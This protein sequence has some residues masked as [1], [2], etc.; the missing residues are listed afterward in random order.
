MASKNCFYVFIQKTFLKL[1]IHKTC[2]L[3]NFGTSW[4]QIE[5]LVPYWIVANYH[6]ILAFHLFVILNNNKKTFFWSQW[7]CNKVMYQYSKFELHQQ[8]SSIYLL[9]WKNEK[10]SYKYG[11]GTSLVERTL[12]TT[13]FW[14]Y[15]YFHVIKNLL[16]KLQLKRPN[17]SVRASHYSI[18]SKICRI[19]IAVFFLS[20]F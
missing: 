13:I 9:C 8:V 17:S 15:P 11:L 4:W 2:Q 19:R 6:I 20:H 3:L 12:V 14:W 18:G 5:I 7:C 1:Q 10:N 16:P